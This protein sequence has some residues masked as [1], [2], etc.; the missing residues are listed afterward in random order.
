VSAPYITVTGVVLDPEASVTV[1]D[2]LAEVQGTTFTATV[3]LE[4]GSNTIKAIAT[5]KASR[6]TFDLIV[7][8][9]KIPAKIYVTYP[10]D[11]AELSV[12]PIY[13]EGIVSDPAT[14]VFVNGVKGT[15]SSDN[16]FIVNGITLGEGQNQIIASVMNRDGDID[17][18]T[19]TIN[20]R[21]IQP[22]PKLTISI[23]SPAD[24]A[25]INKPSTTVVG[26]V[27]SNAD[28]VWVTVNGMPAV[29]YGNQFVVNNLPLT[30]GSNRI[31]VNSMDSN[32]A[33]TRTETTV[34]ADITTQSVQLSSN[35]MSGIAPLTVYF[36]L[37]SSLT[38]TIAS[39]QIDYEG[40]GTI[41][42]SGSTFDNISHTYSTEGIFYPKITM[43]DSKGNVYAD[44]CMIVVQ[45]KA[46]ID[47]LLLAKWQAFKKALAAGRIND[48]VKYFAARSKTA[49]R[50]Q[51]TALSQKLRQIVSDMG[52]ITLV[53]VKG[54]N[55]EYDLRTIRNNKTYSFQV[56]FIQDSDG[57]WRIRSF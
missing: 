33:M 41:D 3:R 1:S 47:S 44:A 11:G 22:Q 50:S 8:R 17:S 55:A 19:I 7:I 6:T 54:H 34:T 52:V 24:G 4:S 20:Y 40:D 21:A 37:S 30:N 46:A 43:T 27:T 31:I 12:T 28:E 16:R 35:V 45:N 42:Y 53:D 5:N 10:F 15:V 51:L 26:T 32:G 23:T 2:V 9:Y 36:T 38:N 57:A 39:Y 25:A 56:L 14:S 18:Q 48:A 49:I 29:I 13:L